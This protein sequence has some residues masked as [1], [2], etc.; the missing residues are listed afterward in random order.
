MLPAPLTILACSLLPC[1]LCL[2]GHS[3]CPLIAPKLTGVQFCDDWRKSKHV[4]LSWII[5]I[6]WKIFVLKINLTDLSQARRLP[7]PIKPRLKSSTKTSY[8]RW[9][10][11]LLSLFLSSLKIHD[12]VSGNH[13][14]C[15]VLTRFFKTALT[16][17]K[18]RE[19]GVESWGLKSRQFLSYFRPFHGIIWHKFSSKKYGV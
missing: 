5:M 1:H 19:T 3:P 11:F 9:P 6:M 4:E 15:P 10:I 16:S 7:A 14:F 12:K 13:D 8:I 2:K 17:D 18:D